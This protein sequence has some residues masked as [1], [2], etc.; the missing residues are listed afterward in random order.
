MTQEQPQLQAKSTKDAEG[1]RK[2][3]DLTRSHLQ[4]GN[5]AGP[6]ELRSLVTVKYEALN[7][8]MN[9]EYLYG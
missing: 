6:N 5:A 3:T 9:T 1:L 4:E 8:L 2:D 7:S